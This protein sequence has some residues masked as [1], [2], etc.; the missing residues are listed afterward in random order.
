MSCAANQI[1]SINV[2]ECPCLRVALEAD[3][4]ETRL[5]DGRK[6]YSQYKS[7]PQDREFDH[8]E[9]EIWE[10]SLYCYL[11]YDLNTEIVNNKDNIQVVKIESAF[12]DDV[13]KTYISE[14]RDNN[15]DVSNY[16]L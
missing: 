15:G 7:I 8:G 4:S 5:T 3:V 14:T 9:S 11:L 12:S 10:E 2:S 6:C 16:I 13:L 1:D